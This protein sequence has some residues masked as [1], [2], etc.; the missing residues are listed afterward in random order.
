MANI[1][2]S[3]LHDLLKEVDQAEHGVQLSSKKVG[4]M[5]FAD[6]IVGVCDSKESMQEAYRCCTYVVR[7]R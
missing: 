6:N 5:L 1:Y 4:E 3:L 7:V 2:I